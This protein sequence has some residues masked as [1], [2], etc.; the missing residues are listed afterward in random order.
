MVEMNLISFIW[1]ICSSGESYE[2]EQYDPLGVIANVVR[3]DANIPLYSAFS[4]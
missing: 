4:M 2:N 1:D 3:I